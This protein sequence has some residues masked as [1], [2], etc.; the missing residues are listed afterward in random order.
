MTSV[1]IA[2]LCIA[3]H[4]SGP[5]LELSPSGSI[6]WFVRSRL[7][8]TWIIEP[9]QEGIYLLEGATGRVH[10]ERLS[11][12]DS[13]YA[14]IQQ[15]QDGTIPVVGTVVVDRPI[16]NRWRR[17]DGDSLS[18]DSGDVVVAFSSAAFADDL[19]DG[20]ESIAKTTEEPDQSIGSTE[21][22]N[23]SETGGTVYHVQRDDRLIT[24][25]DTSS[26]EV[27]ILGY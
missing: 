14:V 6:Q 22:G 1:T 24:V 15:D 12:V 8:T 13:A 26:G 5:E 2:L 23:E 16:P 17:A 18:L 21:S 10:I 3:L 11:S 20:T 27:L 19:S 7:A 9:T 25:S 4:F